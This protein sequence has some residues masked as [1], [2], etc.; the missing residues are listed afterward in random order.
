MIHASPLTTLLLP[1]LLALSLSAF[2]KENLAVTR[3]VPETFVGPLGDGDSL[4]IN[5]TVPYLA[6]AFQQTSFLKI[7]YFSVARESNRVRASGHFFIPSE[8]AA[9]GFGDTLGH[10]EVQALIPGEVSLSMFAYP[11]ECSQS[12]YFTTMSDDAFGIAQRLNL[13]SFAETVPTTACIWSPHPRTAFAAL[14]DG[15]SQDALKL[16]Y[17]ADKVCESPL[18]GVAGERTFDVT[19]S[20]YIQVAA[21]KPDFLSKFGVSLSVKWTANF[22]DSRG[23]FESGKQVSTIGLH[24]RDPKA[25]H[26]EVDDESLPLPPPEVHQEPVAAPEAVRPHRHHHRH[27]RRSSLRTIFAVV[28]IIALIGV[29]SGVIAGLA[30]MFW[31]YRR[32]KGDE[33]AALLGNEPQQGAFAQIAN[34]IPRHTNYGWGFS[35]QQQ[36]PG[37]DHY[38]DQHSFSGAVFPAAQ[39]DGAE[40]QQ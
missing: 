1:S 5:S 13:G 17:S 8:V 22:L 24:K 20:Q 25:K 29:I 37:F 7:R 16:C 39:G 18:A 23:V 10:V 2:C 19:A 38:A 9:L 30:R 31:L 11:P 34:M 15:D 36:P 27:F 35:H 32:Q 21:D 3:M 40:R 33:E 4:C 6:V 28:E 12:R 14:S 26:P